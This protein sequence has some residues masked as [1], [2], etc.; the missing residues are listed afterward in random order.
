MV[1]PKLL[2]P[3]PIT[4][5]DSEPICRFRMANSFQGI[6]RYATCRSDEAVACTKA[7]L[8][9]GKEVVGATEKLTRS[10]GEK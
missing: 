8:G 7:T 6:T 2:V 1:K 3:S 10:A 5:T 4:E 9:R